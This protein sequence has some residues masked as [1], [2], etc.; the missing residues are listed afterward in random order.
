MVS[1]VPDTESIG[2]ERR[3]CFSGWQRSEDSSKTD[4]EV[5][6]DDSSMVVR[7]EM[8]DIRGAFGRQGQAIVDLRG[9]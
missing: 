1:Y 5:R 3:H 2:P 9:D 6:G 8:P 4:E 7:K